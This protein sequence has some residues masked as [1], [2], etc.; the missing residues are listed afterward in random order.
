MKNFNFEDATE[1]V[2]SQL[3]IYDT[4]KQV[5]K[6]ATSERDNGLVG[7][8]SYIAWVA[9]NLDITS[10]DKAA[11]KEAKT[12]QASFL[13]KIENKFSVSYREVAQSFMNKFNKTYRQDL[14]LTDS[15]EYNTIEFI[16]E[17][18]EEDKLKKWD[19]FRNYQNEVIEE[20]LDTEA[21]NVYS[22]LL[23]TFDK[24][25]YSDEI[26]VFETDLKKL[27]LKLQK[28][29]AKKKEDILKEAAQVE[30]ENKKQASA[31]QLDMV[32]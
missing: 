9:I 31:K 3:E 20:Q 30:K 22:Q 1:T 28:V 27:I 25:K 11:R 23:N 15:G 29:R 21:S 13:A 32:A 26:E 14:V 4:K 18:F 7:A 17:I 19:S 16:L 6:T 10:K 5:I 24:S 2:Y 12:K 8:F